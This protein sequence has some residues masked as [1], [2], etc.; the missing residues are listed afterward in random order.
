MA[1]RDAAL[2]YA[3]RDLFVFQA[4]YKRLKTGK[5]NK[6]GRW[7]GKKTNGLNWAM[8]KD[9][10]EIQ[11]LWVSHPDDPLGIPT[12]S[13][14]RIFVLDIDTITV[15]GHRH[16]GFAALRALEGKYGRLPPTLTAQ[17]PTGSVHYYFRLPPGMK[18]KNSASEIVIEGDTRALGIDVRGEG[19]MVIAPP[20]RHPRGGQYRWLNDHDVADAPPWLIE[21]VPKSD[22]VRQRQKSGVA[23]LHVSA[24]PKVARILD[25]V[26][27]AMVRADS[28]KGVS[29]LP[30]DNDFPNIERIKLA[31]RAVPNRDLGWDDWNTVAMAIWHATNGS[32]EGLTILH[33]W[34]RK[35][36]KYDAAETGD[37]WA[38]IT[39]WPPTRF[40]GMAKLVVL[41]KLADPEWERCD[42]RLKIWAALARLPFNEKYQFAVGTAVRA[43]LGDAGSDLFADWGGSGWEQCIDRPG[44]CGDNLYCLAD[45]HDP[46]WRHLYRRMLDAGV[47]S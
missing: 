47:Q 12:G 14:N 38:I 22:A 23:R 20:S 45:K 19:G 2:A 30:E 37:R 36:A 25:P 40:N 44:H 31:C 11:K 9:P 41:A 16:D 5:W 27:T 26:L 29:L 33:A 6:Q 15:D 42:P 21:I 34:S 28:G 17:S 46:T 18:I 13:V 39:K 32:A 8:T 4:R 3:A 24:K 1:H 43:G 35:S 7:S 10:I